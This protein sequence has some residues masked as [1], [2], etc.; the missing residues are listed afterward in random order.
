[1]V[2]GGACRHGLRILWAAFKP[3]GEAHLAAGSPPV[4]GAANAY[5]P[6][7]VATA[8]ERI[9]AALPRLLE[10]CVDV[11]E[12]AGAGAAPGTAGLC[13][14]LVSSFL[15]VRGGCRHSPLLMHE[16]LAAAL[17][18]CLVLSGQT[19]DGAAM[20]LHMMAVY[21]PGFF[22]LGPPRALPAMVQFVCRVSPVPSAGGGA[23]AAGGGSG[24]PDAA[25][26]VA[27]TLQRL[28]LDPSVAQAL[29]AQLAAS[30]RLALALYRLAGENAW[31][32]EASRALSANPMGDVLA[33]TFEAADTEQLR[34]FARCARM[35]YGRLPCSS[36]A[37]C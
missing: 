22:V 18:R 16:V 13:L 29:A 7:G 15:H 35:R 3:A 23:G 19:A 31:G 37:R 30:P 32:D 17:V 2:A 21:K 14:G 24:L 20:M 27:S 4:T 6:P 28:A 25:K 26:S 33:C 11:E 1:M 5:I 10:E 8:T 34:A 36:L 12:A 9:A